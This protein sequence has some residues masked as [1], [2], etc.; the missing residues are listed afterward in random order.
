MN[1]IWSGPTPYDAQITVRVNEL[2]LQINLAKQEGYRAAMNS[3]EVRAGFGALGEI[4]TMPCLSELL[5]EGP[6]AFGEE[7]CGC[8][9][10]RAK[11]GRAAYEAGLM[12]VANAQ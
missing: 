4:A 1:K 9:S 7:G 2:N 5:G 3:P 11:K 6:N 8:A 10:C 12:E